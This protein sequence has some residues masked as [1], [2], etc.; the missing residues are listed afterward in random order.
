MIASL[1]DQLVRDENEI[2][3]AYFDS[4]GYITIG[5]GHLIDARK[6]GAIPE[7]ISRAL[8]RID[9]AAAESFVKEKLP[10]SETL[11]PVRQEAL[12]NMAFNLKGG[13]LE[14]HDFLAALEASNF[15]GAARA[16]L[17]SLWA[18]Q[19][20]DRAKRLSVQIQSGVRQ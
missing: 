10:W 7:E 19:V 6:G 2:L 3:H 17:D 15:Q 11:D 18:K 16:M 9:I 20:G 14:F 8:L 4:L 1:E 12:V 13:L 5:V